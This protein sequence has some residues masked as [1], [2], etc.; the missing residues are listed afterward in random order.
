MA[1]ASTGPYRAKSTPNLLREAKA[2]RRRG[3]TYRAIAVELSGRHPEIGGINLY[4]AYYW[5]QGQVGPAHRKTEAWRRARR[6]TW[7]ERK[8]RDRA[9]KKKALA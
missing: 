7:R 5:S 9:A 1:R 2:L 8:R 3:Y 6:S 4:T